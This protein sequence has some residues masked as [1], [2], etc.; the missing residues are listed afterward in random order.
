MVSWLPRS[1]AVVGYEE[2][3]GYLLI[4]AG[5]R[6]GMVDAGDSLNTN[7]CPLKYYT[8]SLLVKVNPARRGG[9]AHIAVNTE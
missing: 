1:V 7:R 3:V 8:G 6:R 2:L 4:R 5:C 9:Y